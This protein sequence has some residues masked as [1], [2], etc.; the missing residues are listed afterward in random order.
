M[1]A[2][3]EQYVT[4]FERNDGFGGQFQSLIAS[5]IYAELNAAKFVYT[6]FKV[7]A[8]NYDNDP[9]FIAK[10][11]WLI[12][13]KG[14]FEI[15]NGSYKTLSLNHIDFIRFFEAHIVQCA[16]SQALKTMKKIFRANKDIKNY[17]D[18]RTFN[19]VLHVR[20]PNAHDTRIEG[21]DAP[22]TLFLHVI[23]RLRVMYGAKSP[24]FHVF[25]QGSSENF[26]AFNA[27]D[28]Q[29]HLNDSVEDSFTAMVLADVLV[30]AASSFSY[31]AGILS[32]GA[33][34]YIPFW[35]TPLPGWISVYSL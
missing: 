9:D 19:I 30:A 18:G 25:S 14:N 10:K 29:L 7:M 6:P 12:N 32:D 28:V 20:R 2:K 13:F 3:T 21:A 11:E 16:H 5:V 27:P 24:M 34:Y 35:H 23:H 31:V 22:D 17:F 33:V 1:D 8:H 26:K 4:N 15:N